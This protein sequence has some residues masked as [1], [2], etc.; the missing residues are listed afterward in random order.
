M[1]DYKC[2]DCS[3]DVQVPSDALDGEIV[4]CPD[5]GLELQVKKQS[6]GEIELT[7]VTKEKEDWGE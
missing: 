1:P 5:C 6:S 2:T 3:A 4:V 7:E